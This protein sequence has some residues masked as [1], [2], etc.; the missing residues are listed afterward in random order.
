LRLG[1]FANDCPGYDIAIT[2][3]T[4][5]TGNPDSNRRLSH[6]RAQAV[7]DF[8]IRIGVPRQRLTVRGAGST[9]PVARNDTRAGREQNRRIEFALLARPR[10]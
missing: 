4:D 1:E 3:H 10:N 5:S 6:Q 9:E 7:A 2:G 8:L